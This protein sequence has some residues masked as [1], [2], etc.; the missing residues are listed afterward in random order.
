MQ[1]G[2]VKQSFGEQLKI[3]NKKFEHKLEVVRNNI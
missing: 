3:R 1:A 2:P